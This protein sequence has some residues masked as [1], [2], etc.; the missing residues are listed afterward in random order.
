MRRRDGGYTG[1]KITM[2]KIHGIPITIVDHRAMVGPLRGPPVCARHSPT[3]L[4]FLLHTDRGQGRREGAVISRQHPVVM[5]LSKEEVAFPAKVNT[6]AIE[7]KSKTS[8]L[9][10]TSLKEN[11]ISLFS[12]FSPGGPTGL[13]GVS[14]R[15]RLS[16]SACVLRRVSATECRENAFFLTEVIFFR[17]KCS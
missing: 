6:S 13:H 16:L 12:H 17:Q 5:L 8:D 14:Q 15:G 3:A 1:Q 10:A 4:Q 9:K 11:S 7:E 2:V